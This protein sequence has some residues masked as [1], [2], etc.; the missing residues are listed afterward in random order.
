VAGT[1]VV[2]PQSAIC[3]TAALLLFEPL[4]VVWLNR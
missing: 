2:V 3:V 1:L 4:I